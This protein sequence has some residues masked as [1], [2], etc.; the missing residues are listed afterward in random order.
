MFG[1]TPPRRIRRALRAGGP[2]AAITAAIGLGATGVAGGN[3][4]RRTEPIARA[5]AEAVDVDPRL[6]PALLIG[7]ALLVLFVAFALPGL[8]EGHPQ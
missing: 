6:G 5:A 1:V 2:P 8:F 4:E 3:I 7:V